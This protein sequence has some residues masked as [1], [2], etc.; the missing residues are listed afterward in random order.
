VATKLTC[1]KTSFEASGRGGHGARNSRL[2]RRRQGSL[3]RR[4]VVHTIAGYQET[5]VGQYAAE[6][7]KAGF[8][9][10][11][12]D[13]FAARGTTGL[14]SSRSGPAVAPTPRCNHIAVGVSGCVCLLIAHGFAPLAV[15]S[16]AVPRA[17][18]RRRTILSDG[19]LKKSRL[20]D[21]VQ[22]E[23]PGF[24]LA[25]HQNFVRQPER[26]LVSPV[27]RAGV[28]VFLKARTT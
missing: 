28:V 23:L 12:C 8:A 5:N 17:A 4:R 25:S 1:W 11:T 26:S 10:L 22:T 14:A 27:A 2:S 6:L 3:S 7:R 20:G 9:A 21:G 18:C 15:M 16:P 24:F 13:S 19:S